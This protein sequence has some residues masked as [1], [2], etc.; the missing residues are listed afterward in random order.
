MPRSTSWRVDETYVKVRG[1]WAY[2]YRAVDKL[3][4]TID[5]Y[6]SPTRNTAAAKRFLGVRTVCAPAGPARQPLGHHAV[7]AHPRQADERD[8]DP[9]GLCRAVSFTERVAQ[10]HI[11]LTRFPGYWNAKAVN[12]DRIVSRIMPDSTI[13]LANLQSGQLDIANRLA[14]TDVPIVQRAAGLHVAQSASI[15][16]EMISLNLS[17]G[18]ASD[19]PFGRDVRIREAFAKSIDR[20]GI[21]QAVFDGRFVPNNQT[22]PVRSRYWD[23]AHPVPAR[24]VAGARALLQAAGVPH[25]SL[26]LRVSNNPTDIQVGEVIQSMAG[27]AGFEVT[28]N[29]GEAVTQTASATAGDY[30]A[31]LVIWSGRPDPDGNTSIW[32]RCGAPLNWTGYCNK[33]LDAAL[34]RGGASTDPAARIPAYHQAADLWM[35]DLPY[36]PLYHFTWFWGV[37]DKVGGLVPRPDG[38]IRP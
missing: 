1:Q 29:K 27:E 17:H 13:P 36:L 28:L 23:P 24:D 19:T 22:E 16:F 32:L 7:A 34:D 18:P 3:G 21:N 25:P 6:L 14:A 30:Q 4:N 11:T 10:D 20:S 2:L 15:G 31:D 38:L 35:R 12:V 8:R 5:F 37:S 9:P 33:E 26:T